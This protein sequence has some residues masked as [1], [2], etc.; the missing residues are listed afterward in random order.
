MECNYNATKCNR[1]NKHHKITTQNQYK[2]FNAIDMPISRT[3]QIKFLDQ[4]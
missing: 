1:K 4:N 2:C 3:I